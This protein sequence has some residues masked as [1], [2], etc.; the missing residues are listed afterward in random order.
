VVPNHDPSAFGIDF[1]HTA[2]MDILADHRITIDPDEGMK[3]ILFE[4]D[5]R[6]ELI[7]IA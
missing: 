2:D 6:T 1:R 3:G 7:P 4:A 5:E